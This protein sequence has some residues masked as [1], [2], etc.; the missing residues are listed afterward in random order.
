MFLAYSSAIILHDDHNVPLPGTMKEA[1]Y[2]PKI[3]LPLILFGFLIGCVAV[4]DARRAGLAT[5]VERARPIP[6][7]LGGAPHPSDQSRQG[8]MAGEPAE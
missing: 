8:Q 1:P 5:I 3:Y 7:D 4:R 2:D 6:A